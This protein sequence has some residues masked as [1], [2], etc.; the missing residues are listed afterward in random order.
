[1]KKED[2]K[3]LKCFTQK[4]KWG[5][6]DKMDLDFLL[7]LDNY[8]QSLDCGFSIT[9]GYATEGHSPNSYHYKGLAVDGRFT[10]NNKPLSLKETIFL[11]LNSPFMGVGIYSYSWAPFVHFD[12]REA[13]NRVL[14]VSSKKDVYDFD[15]VVI[16]EFIKKAFRE[17]L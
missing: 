14:W 4:E 12:F 10:R 2:W 13:K 16:L 15:K 8:R 3:K 5:S 7:A 1:M 17:D 9:E 6:P 11:A